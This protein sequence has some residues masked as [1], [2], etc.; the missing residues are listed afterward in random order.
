MCKRFKTCNWLYVLFCS[1]LAEK[2]THV[3]V[4]INPHEEEDAHGQSNSDF[5]VHAYAYDKRWPLLRTITVF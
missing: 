3:Y 5:N 4:Y 2:Q 1:R